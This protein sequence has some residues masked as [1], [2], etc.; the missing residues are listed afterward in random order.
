MISGS[1]WT[2]PCGLVMFQ[3]YR[4]RVRCDADQHSFQGITVVS[5]RATSERNKRIT[6]DGVAVT[7]IRE[8]LRKKGAA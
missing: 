6:T 2:T 1:E 5:V 4:E 7:L 8:E 3:S